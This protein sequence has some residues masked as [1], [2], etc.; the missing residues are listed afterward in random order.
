M[1]ALLKI[2][3]QI[4]SFYSTESYDK[5]VW[6]YKMIDSDLQFCK[7][8]KELGDKQIDK[9]LY[10][11]EILDLAI[12]DGEFKEVKTVPKTGIFIHSIVNN[13]LY[14]KA[15]K[16]KIDLENYQNWLNHTNKLLNMIEGES[17]IREYLFGSKVGTL[18]YI[19]YRFLERWLIKNK[20]PL[21]PVAYPVI[22]QIYRNRE[23]I[24]A[25]GNKYPFK[26]AINKEYGEMIYDTL[27]KMRAT[28][29]L[30]VGLAYGG[31]ALFICA[32]HMN[33]GIDGSYHIAIDPNQ[34]TQWHNIAVT[35]IEKLG[36]KGM[37]LIEKPSYQGLPQVLNRMLGDTKWI[38]PTYDP[39]YE[40]MDMCFIDGWHT[41]DATLVDMYYSDLLLKVGGYLIVDDANFDALKELA[42]FIDSNW[43]H[44]ERVNTTYK[45]FMMYRKKS[46]DERSW[47]FHVNFI[48]K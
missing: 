32:A 41:Y 1:E 9:Q 13:K 45:L 17:M 18:R 8:F 26:S 36:Y 12:R 7:L 16:E 3:Y 42:Q 28:K 40:R 34:S 22:H 24:D 37:E 6:K 39:N 46:D 11:E 20:I 21:K 4:D 47:N 43:H 25:K 33:L 30:E 44:Y 29:T 31:S 14:R 27:V 38:N 19:Q 15:G 35:N 48:K 10:K 2:L 23:V 5:V